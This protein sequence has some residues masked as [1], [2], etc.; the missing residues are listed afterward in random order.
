MRVGLP[1]LH[2]SL[3]RVMLLMLSVTVMS[4]IALCLLAWRLSVLDQAVAQQRDRERLDHAADSGSGALLQ[5]VNEIGDRLRSLVDSDSARNPHSLGALADRCG[6]CRA[7]LI[8]PGR[9]TLFPAT[10]L[11]YVPEPPPPA[12]VDDG[13]FGGGEALEFNRRDYGASGQW[14]LDLAKHS[15]GGVRAGALIRAARNFT[16]GREFG[17]AVAAWSSLEELG[18]L[19]VN[20]EPCDLVARFARLVLLGNESRQMEAQR[21]QTDLDSGRW[22]LARTSYEFYSGELSKVTGIQPPPPVWE[23]AVY[24]IARFARDEHIASGER[25]LQSGS[26]IPVLAVWRT[27]GEDIAGMVFTPADIGAWLARVPGFDFGLET[28]DNQIILPAPKEKAHADR[29]LSFANEHWRLT[30]AATHQES[31]PPNRQ[32]LLLAGLSLVIVLV[33][34]GSYAVVKAVSRE[35]AVA[36]LQTDFV[37]AVSHEFRSPLTTLRSMS[38]MLERGRVPSEERK[39]RYYS[40]IS[41]ETQ[42]LHRLVEDLLDFGRMEAGKKQYDKRPTE[43]STLVSQVVAETSE[44]YAAR[45]FEI[46]IRGMSTGLVLGDPDALRTAVRNLLENAV[47]YSADSRRVDVEVRSAEGRVS[48]SVQDYGMGISRAELKKI[49]RKFERGS[50]AKASSI[51][52]TGLGLAMVHGI[53]RAHGGSVRVETEENHGSTFT[54]LIPCI[55]TTQEPQA[56]RAS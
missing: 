37:S 43:M 34:T 45:G 28:L 12:A 41:R 51:Q 49:F 19:P 48:V 8:E 6:S 18:A 54:L 7:I 38:E 55:A 50:A 39:Q 31:E 3:S 29:V 24:S 25:V 9:V 35:L 44:E 13:V 14:F 16:K 40:L 42:R 17:S 20:G 52:G 11:R 26:S 22:R 32:M 33:L 10:N 47:K 5:N 30:A 4:A 36:Q 46:S 21:L 2:V 53:L 1:W 27:R 15:N 23:E 56:C